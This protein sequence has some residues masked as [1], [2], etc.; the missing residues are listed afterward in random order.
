MT[1]YQA[2]ACE[3]INSLPD[4]KLPGV[5]EFLKYISS[6]PTPLDDFDYELAMRADMDTSEY[7]VSLEELSS[8]YGID[9]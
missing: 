1:E 5:I 4:E 2:K 6:N 3:I 8:R 9:L 7:T